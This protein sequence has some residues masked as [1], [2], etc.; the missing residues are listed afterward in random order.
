MERNG[1]IAG[2][3][4]IETEAEREEERLLHYITFPISFISHKQSWSKT[5]P[6][7]SDISHLHPVRLEVLQYKIGLVGVETIY[8]S[9]YYIYRQYP[10]LFE[11]KGYLEALSGAGSAV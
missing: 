11:T 7:N 5:M 8:S 10:S 4:I 6:K 1:W 9:R 3:R 2:R